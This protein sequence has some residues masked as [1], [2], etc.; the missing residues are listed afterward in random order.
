MGALDWLFKLH[1]IAE[2]ND[3]LCAPGHGDCISE[4]YLACFINEKKVENPFPL[5][6]G[7]EPCRP[8]N[9]A[10]RISGARILVAFNV[11]KGGIVSKQ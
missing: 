11:L 4:R 8:T 3:I 7:K 2:K 9:H 1:L 6:Q 5:R 10:V